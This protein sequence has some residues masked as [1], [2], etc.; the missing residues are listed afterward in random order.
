[1]L[2]TT[3]L[4]CKIV[5][6]LLALVCLFLSPSSALGKGEGTPVATEL[7]Y[8]QIYTLQM[9]SVGAQF[10]RENWT[11]A[12]LTPRVALCSA[13]H[14]AAQQLWLALRL[15]T[16][17]SSPSHPHKSR[18]GSPAVSLALTLPHVCTGLDID[19][20]PRTDVSMYP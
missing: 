7:C 10:I 5:P 3:T 11:D 2:Q 17:S 20:V 1:M 4:P 16:S 13:H 18:D 12:S 8:P 6:L 14:S 19:S 15:T 9:R